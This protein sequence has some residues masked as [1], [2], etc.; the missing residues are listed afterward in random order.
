MTS[1]PKFDNY[2]EEGKRD[3]GYETLQDFFLSW[4]IRCSPEHYK[5]SNPKVQEYARRIVYALIIGNN[6]SDEYSIEKGLLEIP[7]NFRIKHVQTRRQL[8]N[9]D[10]IAE[11]TTMKDGF[12]EKYLLN[13]ENKWYSGL[14]TGQLERYK[15]FVEEHYRGWEIVNLFITCDDCRKNYKQEKEECTLHS[16]K[17]L[18]I[19]DLASISNLE[20]GRTENALF[21]EYW[22]D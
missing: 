12:S 16:Y 1:L 17:Y 13:I 10:L 5:S 3:S 11:V 14:K 20:E 7:D 19:G 15:S 4:T 18:T 9:I 2:K 8:G 22:F 6:K 21:D